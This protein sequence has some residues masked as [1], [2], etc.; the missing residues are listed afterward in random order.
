[1]LKHGLGHPWCA[2]ESPRDDRAEKKTRISKSVWCHVSSF[3][4]VC[5]EEIVH[6]VIMCFHVISSSLGRSAAGAH[7]Q[8]IRACAVETHFSNFSGTA[9]Q[10]SPSGSNIATCFVQP[11]V[12]CV[13]M[14]A[15]NES[16]EK[17]QPE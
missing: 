10:K 4:D 15:E 6:G 1:M 13:K 5:V 11:I 7:M 16:M 12:F 14:D 17:K 8:S 3:F 9:I 2:R